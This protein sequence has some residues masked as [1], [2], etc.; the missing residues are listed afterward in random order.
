MKKLTLTALLVLG[1]S[2]CGQSETAKQAEAFSALD[3]KAAV[4]Q[5]HQWYKNNDGIV[6][7]VHPD[8]VN[9]TFSDGTEADVAIPNGEFYLSIAP[10]ATFTHPCG[11]HVPTGCTGELIGQPMHVSAV[12]VDSGEEVINTM[13][14]TQHDGFIDFWVPA[15]RQ[16]AFT[17]HFDHPEYGMLEAKE[18]LPTFED[19][20]TCITTMQLKPMGGGAIEAS[21][22]GGHS[23]HH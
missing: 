19:S 2:A 5:G 13:I 6:V 16:L 22:H 1:L 17:F 21:G 3:H 14:T 20:R 4:L 18:V 8:R 7:R 11:N 23:A 12:D 10:W 9:A 15:Q